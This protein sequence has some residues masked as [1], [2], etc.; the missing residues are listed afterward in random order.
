[1]RLLPWPVTVRLHRG[2]QFIHRGASHAG[3]FGAVPHRNLDISRDDADGFQRSLRSPGAAVLGFLRRQA[4]QAKYVT[5]VCTG[6]LVLG[7]AGLLWSYR[8]TTHWLSLPLLRHFGA[9]PVDERVVID[10]NRVTSGG[11]T[12]GIDFGLHLAAMLRGETI[13]RQIQLQMEYNPA[14]PFRSGSPSTAPQDVIE[15][16]RLAA[17]PLQ[18]ERSTVARKW[19][20]DW[21]S[22]RHP[23]PM[24]AEPTG[25]KMVHKPA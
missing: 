20:K 1:M 13:A 17:E 15:T 8:A 9:I 7:A 24:L 16:V 10:R 25:I 18:Q 5:S 21:K 12:S 3:Q 14:P 4:G 6:A 19:Q 23:A 2:L 11:V 22:R